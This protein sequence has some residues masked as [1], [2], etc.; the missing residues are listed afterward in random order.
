[1]NEPELFPAQEELIT[2]MAE[3][4]FAESSVM[5]GGHT[6][7]LL[8]LT[9]HQSN[10]SQFVVKVNA[11]E[12]IAENMTGYQAIA[13]LGA[14]V[15][16]PETL[17][18]HPIGE[19]STALIMDYLGEPLSA[20]QEADFSAVYTQFEGLAGNTLHEGAQEQ[21][22]AGLMSCVESTQYF[23]QRH[24]IEHSVDVDSLTQKLLLAQ[25][26]LGVLTSDSATI[27][28]LDFTPDNLFFDPTDETIRFIDPW[29]Q[30]SYVGSMLVSIGQ[31]S[32]L[33]DNIYRLPAAEK[34][35]EALT[36][37]EHKIASI[38]KLNVQQ[39]KGHLLLGALLQY[40]LSSYA[41][42]ENNQTSAIECYT[43]AEQTA[44]ELLEIINQLDGEY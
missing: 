32:T 20:D 11:N 9:A 31:F 2:L 14:K 5:A 13:E 40:V 44:D 28:L 29:Q 41:R 42:Y 36:E 33:A 23:L 17:E 18:T 8:L 39:A 1:M 27:Q 34:A 24:A 25:S 12:S 37:T 16:I 35:R 26:N 30:S 43:I 21:L 7:S 10:G 3:L 4:D 6:D 15:L 22:E 38:L 19:H